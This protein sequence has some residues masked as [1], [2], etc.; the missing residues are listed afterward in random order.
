M[1]AVERAL[2]RWGAV[3]LYLDGVLC[4]NGGHMARNKRKPKLDLG[5]SK[6]AVDAHRRK[7][8]IHADQRINHKAAR[9]AARIELRNH[10]AD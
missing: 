9:K 4:Y 8:G 6:V 3:S 1:R 10:D 7:G 5:P 2:E